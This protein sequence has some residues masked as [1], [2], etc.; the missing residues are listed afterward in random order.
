MVQGYKNTFSN[1]MAL[2]LCAKCKLYIVPSLLLFGWD[3]F[4]SIQPFISPCDFI[5]I[6]QLR[7]ALVCNYSITDTE[8]INI[9][10]VYVERVLFSLN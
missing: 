3:F 1:V 9:Q 2:L 10:Q 5:G 7:E 6:N 8:L 4:V